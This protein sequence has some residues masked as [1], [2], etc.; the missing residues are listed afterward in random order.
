MKKQKKLK[1][2]L[3]KTV[4]KSLET[5]LKC[6]QTDNIKQYMFKVGNKIKI[7]HTFDDMLVIHEGKILNVEDGGTLW[8]EYYPYGTGDTAKRERFWA[9]QCAIIQEPR[10]VYVDFDGTDYKCAGE[11]FEGS[12]EFI[13]ITINNKGE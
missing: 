10:K 2:K 4:L 13:E 6:S 7:Y 11:P 5:A 9:K 12:T 3:Y 1:K 8:T